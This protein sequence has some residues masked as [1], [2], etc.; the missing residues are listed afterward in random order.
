MYGR[1]RIASVH[2]MVKEEAD[3]FI[4]DN[5]KCAQ[6]R[7]VSTETKREDECKSSFGIAG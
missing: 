4:E 2:P 7:L 3:R 6:G 1:Q 5:G